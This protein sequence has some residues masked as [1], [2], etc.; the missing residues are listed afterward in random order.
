MYVAYGLIAFCPTVRLLSRTYTEPAA[1]R[2]ALQTTV[3]DG[4]L[5]EREGR[6]AALETAEGAEVSEGTAGTTRRNL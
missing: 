5:K 6:Y 2:D 3:A 4:R 1:P